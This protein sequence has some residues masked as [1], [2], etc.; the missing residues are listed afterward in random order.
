MT[1]FARWI[2]VGLSPMLMVTRAMALPVTRALEERVAERI[3]DAWKI[4]LGS[5][6]MQWGRS[7]SG[8]S[9]MADAPFKVMGR[10]QGGW[11]VVVFDPSDSNAMAIRL[12]A[13]VEQPVMVAAQPLR[14]GTRLTSGDLREEVRAI[15]NQLDE[16]EKAS[17][18]FAGFAKEIDHLLGRIKAIEKHLGLHSSIAA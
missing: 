14:P 7:S 2:V 6:R 16:F 17:R 12:R 11:F 10:G 9:P 15:R 1:S 8:V 3:A 4:P 18:N 5:L 13:G